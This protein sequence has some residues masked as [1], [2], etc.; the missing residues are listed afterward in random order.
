MRVGETE[1]PFA[2]ADL[3]EDEDIEIWDVDVP[4]GRLWVDRS[5]TIWEGQREWRDDADVRAGRGNG[6]ASGAENQASIA[7][8]G[9]RRFPLA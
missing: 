4:E 5:R 3:P 9:H 2:V 1:A 8:R 7:A 6:G